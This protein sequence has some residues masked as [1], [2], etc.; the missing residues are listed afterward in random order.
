MKVSS[1][2]GALYI[3]DSWGGDIVVVV[4]VELVVI[5]SNHNVGCS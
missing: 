5:V 3:V 1:H 2:P 4:V